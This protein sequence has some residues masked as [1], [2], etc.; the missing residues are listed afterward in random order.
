MSRLRASTKV[1]E[2]ALHEF[3]YRYA[4]DCALEA[5]SQQ[6]TQL[7]ITDKFAEAARMYGLAIN[8]KKTKLMFQPASGNAYIAANVSVNGVSLKPVKEFC[9]LGSMLANDALID[10]EV[11]NHISRSST[12][13]GLLYSKIWNQNSLREGKH[14]RCTDQSAL[15][16]RNLDCCR[17]HIKALD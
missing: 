8:T 11:E 14:G 7:M 1:F 12:S 10:K 16:M 5:H 15:R 6:D 3:L 4:D 9:Y 2:Q 17:R 13:L